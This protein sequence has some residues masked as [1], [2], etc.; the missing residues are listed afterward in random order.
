MQKVGAKKG[1][2]Q[3]FLNDANIARKIVSSLDCEGVRS[4]IEIG[5][6]TGILTGLLLQDQFP[7]FTA[8]E[9]DK[10]SIDYLRI[11]Y[12][13]HAGRFVFGDFLKYPLEKHEGP[14]A[15]IGNLPYFISSQIFFRAL[16][17]RDSVS[18]MVFMI[19]KEVA[20]RI[21][22]PPGN[23]T[24]GILSVLL[25]AYYDIHYLF[26][27]H[28]HCFS[29]APRV[30]SAVIRLKRN[31]RDR[32]DCEHSDFHKVVKATFNQRRKTIR[33]SLKS[34]FLNLP[35]GSELLTK[36]PE[37]LTVEQFAELTRSLRKLNP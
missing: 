13:E 8:V 21:A 22:A 29:P 25:Q 35:I 32:L 23:K 9:L 1:L 5:P 33:N 24:Y 36:R 34:I 17:Y 28:E 19:Q 31:D 16:E 26:T 15:L 2:G 37:Q 10:E 12:P 6:G 18:Q 11:H 3:H 27:V 4:L 30:K 7:E 20:E 14:I